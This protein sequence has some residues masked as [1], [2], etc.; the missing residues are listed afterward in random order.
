LQYSSLYWP[1]H[2]CFTPDTGDLGMWDNLGVLFGG[3]YGL[4]WIEVLSLMRM[5]PNGVPSL[6][7]VI[8]WAKVSM[9]SGCQ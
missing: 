2:L 1:N 7:R 3:L 8:S 9:P 4:F 5:V 6:R